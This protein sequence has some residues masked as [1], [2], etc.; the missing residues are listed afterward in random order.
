MQA[1]ARASQG[2]CS[3]GSVCETC[4]DASLERDAW[5]CDACRHF[6]VRSA[7]LRASIDRSY[8]MA[9]AALRRVRTADPYNRR[10]AKLHVDAC[11]REV[12]F[13]RHRLRWL[14]MSVTERAARHGWGT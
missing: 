1:M 3:T 2:L 11:R 12:T 5:R 4:G 10:L 9:H 7:N 14:R 8:R 6:G 13:A